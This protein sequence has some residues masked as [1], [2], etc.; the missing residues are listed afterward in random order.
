MRINIIKQEVDGDYLCSTAGEF[1]IR[2]AVHPYLIMSSHTLAALRKTNDERMFERDG[3]CLFGDFK[4][5][6][7]NDLSFG[8]VDIR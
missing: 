4:V 8:N 6:I 2:E 5:L 1:A 7:N 3:E